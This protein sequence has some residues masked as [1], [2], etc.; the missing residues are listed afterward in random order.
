V[1]KV[2]AGQLFELMLPLSFALTALLS[3]WVLMSARR[4]L[5]GAAT[6]TLWTLGTLFFPLIILPL[7]LVARS[8]RRR[9]ENEERAPS[10]ALPWRRTLPLLYL[11][12][13]LSLYAL[14]FYIDSR[15]AEAHLMR[16]N[17]ARVRGQR[18]QV[19][20]EYR[21][22]LRVEDDAHTHNLLAKEYSAA[23]RYDEALREFRT[24]ERMGEIDE[25]LS[26]NI[27][28][29]LDLL[30]HSAEAVPEYERFLNDSLCREMPYDV[31]CV[32]ARQRVA[33]IAE[34]ERR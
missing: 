10:Q 13:L 24:A 14:Y 8:F 17:Q 15:G 31:R 28:V 5:F 25:E 32:A 16:A 33:K 20:E 7:Y 29:S 23:M 1:T 18:E 22:A 26:F 30:N 2:S 27:A 9:D 3:T 4:H 11:A 19:I 12:T 34:R 6:V 21:A